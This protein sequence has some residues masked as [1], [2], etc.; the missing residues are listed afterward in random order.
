MPEPRTPLG[1]ETVTKDGR[2]TTCRL[3]APAPQLWPEDR[4]L[5]EELCH[6]LSQRQP[7]REVEARD[8]LGVALRQLI[9]Q[10]QSEAL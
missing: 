6:E 7:G 3:G 8:I 1:L 9:Q 4:R 5:V 10:L 2:R